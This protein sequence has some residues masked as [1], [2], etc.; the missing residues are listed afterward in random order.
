MPIK[1]KKT[2]IQYDI[3]TPEIGWVIIGADEDGNLVKKDENGLYEKIIK[4]ETYGIYIK[5]ETDYLTIGNRLSTNEG[6]YSYSQGE[7]NESSNLISTS[8]GQYLKSTN[9]LSYASGKGFGNTS[10]NIYY[11]Y[12]NGVNSFVHSYS[13]NAN[14]YGSYSDYSVI[15][16][17]TNNL[18][19]TNANSSVILGGNN[20]KILENISGT[21]IIGGNGIIANKTNTLYTPNI[22]TTGLTSLTV[23][24]DTITSNSINTINLNVSTQLISN[25]ITSNQSITLGIN[26]SNTFKISGYTSSDFLMANGTVN[27]DRYLSISGGT[28]YDKLIQIKSIVSKSTINDTNV[29]IG[30]DHILNVNTSLPNINNNVILGYGNAKNL[31]TANTNIIIGYQNVISDSFNTPI[32]NMNNNIIIGNSNKIKT[33]GEENEIIIGNNLTGKG[34]GTISLG[35]GT[36]WNGTYLNGT[37]YQN[38]GSIHSSDERLKTDIRTLTTYEIKAAKELLNEIGMY[39]FLKSIQEKGD[40]A[41]EHVGMT[42]QRAIQ[43]MRDNNLDP[44]NYAFICRDMNTD[45]PLDVI[46]QNDPYKYSFR[47]LELI[48]FITRGLVEEI[49]TINNKIDILE[50]KLL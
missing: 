11:L 17:G 34:S 33:T 50:S 39:K 12:S 10:T 3:D 46:Y 7:Y 49:K 48:I 28:M 15:L 29:V 22:I 9:K 41:R 43:I 14:N 38:D 37:I 42:V 18:I 6:L 25:Y 30:R 35:G 32:I 27:T 5:L 13:T 31:T 47:Y 40:R 16:G 45:N 24:G 26:Y 1:L 2:N 8:R 4:D 19:E 36:G 21:T 23:T 20:N 44:F